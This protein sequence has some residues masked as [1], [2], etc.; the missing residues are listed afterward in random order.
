[1][2]ELQN[3]QSINN[4]I[5]LLDY[6]IILAKHSRMIIYVSVAIMVLTYLISIALPNKYIARARLLPP[7]QNLTLSAQL[8]N[9]LGGGGTPGAPAGVGGGM[10]AGLLGLKSPSD[11]YVSM[12][13]GDTIFDRIINRFNLRKLYK[14][15]YIETTRSTLS[16]LVNIS[17]QKDGIITV[18][19]TDKDPKRAAEMANA[20]AEELDKLLQGLATQEAKGRL[21]FLEKERDQANQNLTK[22]ENALRSFSEQNNVIQIDTQTRGVLEYIARLRAEIDAKEVQIQVMRQ[23]AT[24][25]NY[26]MVKL[27]TEVQG[28]KNK[29]KMAENQ[30][31]PTCVDDVCLTTNKVPA[32]GLEYLRLYRE[33]KFQNA[34]HQLYSKVVELARLDMVKDFSVVQVVDKALPP[35][36]RSNKRLLPALLAGFVTGFM[37]IF[38]AFI[39]EFWQKAEANEENSRRLSALRD[40]LQQWAHPFR[41]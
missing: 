30:Y 23:Q 37:M 26:D 27:E 1:M 16:K 12:M 13:L 20:F 8:L 19:V 32:L 18:E 11:L 5:H 9:T 14:E 6:L 33:V 22:A 39:L 31:D 7:Q 17:A 25:F 40:N 2:R 15:K 28:L 38:F 4:D 35:E 29:L 21:A 10:V 41:R 3:N 34:L 24:R 36:V